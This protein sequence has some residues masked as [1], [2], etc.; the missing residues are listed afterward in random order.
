MKSNEDDVD[1]SKNGKSVQNGDS[2]EIER[3]ATTSH[4]LILPSSVL[5]VTNINDAVFSKADPKVLVI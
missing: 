5:I 3:Q 2:E 1:K 4:S